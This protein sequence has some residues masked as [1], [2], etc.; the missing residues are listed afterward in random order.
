M[1]TEPRFTF[2]LIPAFG[3]MLLKCITRDQ[4]K[5]SSTPKQ[6]PFHEASSTICGGT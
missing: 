6:R 3:P 1:T 5:T 2:H 4:C